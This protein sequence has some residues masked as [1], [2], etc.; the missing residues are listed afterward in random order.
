MTAVEGL[1]PVAERARF[2]R[3]S[4]H[5]G[6]RMKRLA[7]WLRRVLDKDTLRLV[8][9]ILV[10]Q[11]FV[12]LMGTMNSIMASSI[13]KTTVSA[14]GLV[15]SLNNLVIMFFSAL[16]VGATVVVAHYTARM[17]PGKANETVKQ[18]LYASLVLVLAAMGVILGFETPVLTLLFGAVE[19]EVMDN[20]RIYLRYAALSYP[21]VA[22]TGIAGGVMRGASDSKTPMQISVIMN[23]VN[24]AFGY[25]LIYGIEIGGGVIGR[26]GIAGAGLA[27][28]IA[29]GVGAALALYTMVRGTRGVQLTRPFYFKPDIPI[30]KSVFGIGLPAS[31]EN[32]FFNAGKIITQ[33]FIVAAGTADL[34]ANYLTGPIATITNLP[35]NAMS[36]ACATLVGQAMGVRDKARAKRTM[37]DLTLLAM[38]SMAVICLPLG[39]LAKP[40][41][42]I[43]NPAPDVYPLALIF[44]RLTCIFTPLFWP[45]SFLLPGGL[46]SAGDARFCMIISVTT[47]WVVRVGIGYILSVTLGQGALG[48]W[49]AMFIDWAARSVIYIFRVRSGRWGNKEVIYDS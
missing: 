25:V 4:L 9:P 46:R 42:S 16:S 40:F 29:R 35:G 45:G 28:L 21:F 5:G 41:L 24:V 43:Y 38:L 34:A 3:M 15:D 8:L 30:L 47:L 36:M 20:T 31:M 7:T 49:L 2:A 37:V 12:M 33:T 19:P 23:I 11:T 22:I 27:I 10:E 48:V 6:K 13:G 14:I 1:F 18:A 32:L 26:L 17:E 44:V 39:L